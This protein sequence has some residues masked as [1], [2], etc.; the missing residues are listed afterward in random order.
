[1]NIGKQI[2]VH[3]LRCNMT[4]EQLSDA[5]H[6]TAQAVSK[7]ENGQS[8]PD[9][10]ML[11][12]LSAVLGVRIDDL[13]ESSESAVLDRIDHMLNREKPFSQADFEY[14]VGRL[15]EGAAHPETRGRCL[16]LL[17]DVHMLQSRGY[18]QRAAEYARQALEIDPEKKDNHSLLFQAMR[19]PDSD[20]CCA[21]HTELVDFYLDFTRKH[22]NYPQGY[23][24]LLDVL[25]ADHRL[26]E[27]REAL[28]C[29]AKVRMSYH[30]PLYEGWIAHAEGD[31][32]TAQKCWE[33]VTREYPDTWFAWSSR[34][35]VC[36]FLAQYDEALAFYREASKRQ[37]APRFY[38]NAD[39]IMQ[40]CLLKG[41][42]AGAAEACEDVIAILAQDWQMTEGDTVERYREKAA[43][44]RAQIN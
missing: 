4:Q 31:R 34:G 43:W 7:W 16:T 33:R 21:T 13:F 40:L 6:V 11:P 20:W 41:D 24:W 44:C 30:V 9:I 29:M 18:A 1:M 42:Y 15:N 32:E 36:A 25:I 37:T 14:V 8:L 3:R 17:S 12:A 26:Q 22:P 28:K 38:D 27:A 2:R 23:L 19:G 35:D 5:L 39:S 10:A